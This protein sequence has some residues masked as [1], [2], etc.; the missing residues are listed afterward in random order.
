MKEENLFTTSFIINNIYYCKYRNG[1]FIRTV[2]LGIKHTEKA[3]KKHFFRNLDFPIV[4]KKIISHK[5]TSWRLK[6][7]K[8][9]PW[10][11]L[12]E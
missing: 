8:S 9:I 7:F 2:Y 6:N 5:L 11:N 1:K 10:D 3:G 4:G 12:K